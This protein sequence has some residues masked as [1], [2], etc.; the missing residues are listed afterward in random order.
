M[1]QG[2][3]NYDVDTGNIALDILAETLIDPLNW[4]TLFTKS[5][6]TIGA[7]AGLNKAI[8][9]KRKWRCS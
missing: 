7:K 1:G 5:G 6:L 3:K 4:I 8:S 2:R 9:K